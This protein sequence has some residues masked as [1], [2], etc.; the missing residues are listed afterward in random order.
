MLLHFFVPILILL[1][2]FSNGEIFT[3]LADMEGL[4]TTEL[5]LVRHLEDYIKAEETKLERM[6]E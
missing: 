6:R 5:Q 4:V 3:A 1:P 2:Y